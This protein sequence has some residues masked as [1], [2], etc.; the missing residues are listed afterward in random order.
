[1]R[2]FLLLLVQN[3]IS[4]LKSGSYIK[5]WGALVAASHLCRRFCGANWIFY[6]G[7][8]AEECLTRSKIGYVLIVRSS[9]MFGFLLR[10][11]K[12]NKSRIKLNTSCWETHLVLKRI[13]TDA[14]WIL[15]RPRPP[16]NQ[17]TS[18]R[19]ILTPAVGLG[20]RDLLHIQRIV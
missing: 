14:S 19:K 4:T 5:P 16:G 18:S 7:G 12:F 13:M 8:V 10:Y 2:R 3:R 9:Q 6:L 15:W 1:M 11:Y 17:E 20:R